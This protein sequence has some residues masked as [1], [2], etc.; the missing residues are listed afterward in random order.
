[1][2]ILF[3]HTLR[4]IR[5]NLGQLTV[6]LLTI[7]VV[8][9]MF[10]VTV[11]IGG[12]FR[13]LQ[14]SL[15]SRL[16]GDTD[17][18]IY[19]EAF[20]DARLEDFLSD[21]GETVEYVEKYLRTGAIFKPDKGGDS[22]IIL[23]EITDLKEFSARHGRE[24]K[25]KAGSEL[26]YDYPEVWVGESFAEEN[27]IKAGEEV[28]IYFRPYRG[29]RKLTV[30]YI[31][32]N[33]GIFANS[34]VNNVLVDFDSAGIDG[35]LTDAY[36]KLAAGADADDFIKSVETDFKGGVSASYSVDFAEVDKIV[37]SNQ[38]LLNIT[39]IFVTMLMGFI[40]FT[41]YLVIAKK[42]AGEFS[43]FLAVGASGV[44]ITAAMLFEGL[45]YGF[46]GSSAG[47][48]LGRF[49]MG[50]AVKKLIPNFPD[51][52]TFSV[53]DYILTI[54]FG[55]AISLL[56]AVIP[57]SKARR[58]SISKTVKVGGRASSEYRLVLF[59]VS[60]AIIAASA[61]LVVKV[62]KYAVIFTLLLTLSTA[63]FAFIGVVY[64]IRGVSASMYK[65]AGVPKLS[66]CTIKRNPL[67]HILA[68]MVGSIIVLTFIAV[69]IV[70]I[71]KGAIVPASARFS[72]DYV[73]EKTES[74]DMR[75]LN[76]DINTIEGVKS[77]ICFYD[78]CTWSLGAQTLEYRVYGVDDGNALGHLAK[79]LDGGGWDRDVV[80]AF[81]I[82]PNPVIV[83]YDLM[84]RLNLEKGRTIRLRHFG[85]ER[86][87][88]ELYDD[89]KIVGVDYTVTADDRIMIIKNS[90]FRR[91]R[92]PYVPD[93]SI[94]FVSLTRNDMPGDDVYREI[95]D[96]AEARF[97]FSLKFDDWANA[98]SVGIRGVAALLD[99]LQIIVGAVALVG[100]INLTV[101]TMIER[102]REFEIL[103]SSGADDKKFRLL[104]LFES[105]IISC[106]GIIVGILLSFVINLLMPSFG[107]IIDRYPVK[108]FFPWEIAVI[109]AAVAAVY[110]AVYLLCGE[111]RRKKGPVERNIL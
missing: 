94:I 9:A 32:E 79:D 99:V 2:N 19:S 51:A 24:L 23:A 101:V 43:R 110:A 18:R 96:R 74:C 38:K 36:V 27:G 91:D 107:Q 82:E 44:Q 63:V 15:K 50:I 45:L 98:T 53:F 13:N 21:K 30:T 109:S 4:S 90:S 75:K 76:E 73:V 12:L 22:K 83:S 57:V 6:I 25:L 102:Q 108:R 14:T 61:V 89:F 41:S 48:I 56:S 7:T 58:E 28:E 37:A 52:V 60:P 69:S 40:L 92:K 3:R 95:R 93:S 72:A 8:A 55:T 47:C 106:G 105:M 1:M 39:L 84:R 59:F 81:E 88:W 71:I 54:V 65:L 68:G 87:R 17:V 31:F 97:C 35:I 62:P 26:S 11:T 85:A 20:S 66:G 100:V 10:F 70:D 29:Y 5:D 86:D 103:R 64:I 78:T 49:G 16:S 34:V 67:S 46:S 111:L 104:S 77:D 42:R 33:V 80:K